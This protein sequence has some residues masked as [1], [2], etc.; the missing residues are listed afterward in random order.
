MDNVFYKYRP[1]NDNTVTTLATGKVWF[2]THRELNDPL[3]CDPEVIFDIDEL[4]VNRFFEIHDLKLDPCA[5]NEEK[6]AIIKKSYLETI[7]E[8]GVFCVSETPNNALM[9]AHYGDEHRGLVLGFKIPDKQSIRENAAHLHPLEMSYAGRGKLLVS[10]ILKHAERQSEVTDAFERM[11]VASF[12]TK[13]DNWRYESE[14]RFLAIDKNGLID[15]EATLYSITYGLRFD[16]E[17][18]KTI[19]NIVSPKTKHQQVY[20]DGGDLKIRAL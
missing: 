7:Q 8:S 2:A 11:M 14:H 10:D 15:L 5:T 20:V 1:F 17:Q 12:F 16:F 13:T 18:L 19:K 6:I 9:W 4:L 3:D